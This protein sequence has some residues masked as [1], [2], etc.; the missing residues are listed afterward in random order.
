MLLRKG[1]RCLVGRILF[2]C[3]CLSKETATDADVLVPPL[4]DLEDGGFLLPTLS[5]YGSRTSDF[6]FV[7]RESFLGVDFS[8]EADEVFQGS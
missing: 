1:D 2:C 8:V 3:F 7:Q 6:C 5:A 4:L